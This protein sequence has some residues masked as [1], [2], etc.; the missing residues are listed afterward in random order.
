M[1]KFKL[2]SRLEN[3]SILIDVFE[4]IQIRTI[5]DSRYIWFILVPNIS[6]LKEWHDLPRPLEA[7]L[8]FFTRNLSHFLSKTLNTTKIN[9]ASLGNVV[10]QF[11]LHIVARYK[12]NPSWPNPVW[13]DGITLELKKDEIHMRKKLIKDFHQHLSNL[14]KSH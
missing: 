5:N 13:G 3:D 12:D 8:L 11:H 2:D 1:E 14:K 7:N 6:K 10:S 9:I 4:G